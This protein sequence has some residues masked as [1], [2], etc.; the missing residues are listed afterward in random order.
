[1]KRMIEEIKAA[2]KELDLKEIQVRVM[3]ANIDPELMVRFISKDG[4]VFDRHIY[5]RTVLMIREEF[6]G[7]VWEWIKLEA[8]ANLK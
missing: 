4:K 8:K 1:M 2:V 3:A 7:Q 6:Q 5:T